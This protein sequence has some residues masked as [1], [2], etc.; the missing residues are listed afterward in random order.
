MTHIQSLK[1][2]ALM[3]AHKEAPKAPQTI[4]IVYVD[5]LNPSLILSDE[6]E[7]ISK[8]KWAKLSKAGAILDVIT[9]EEQKVYRVA[10]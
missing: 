4:A 3:L 9:F 1:D 7:Y 8:A 6:V 5:K 2:R 10:I